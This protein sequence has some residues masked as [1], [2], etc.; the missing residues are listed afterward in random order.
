VTSRRRDFDSWDR[1]SIG[2][3]F[4]RGAIVFGQPIWIG[5]DAQPAEVEAARLA[6]QDG[7][8]A[9]HAR[10]YALVGD[11]DPGAGRSSV[12]EARARAAANAFNAEPG[13]FG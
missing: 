7:L 10:A 9:A 4:G 2:L 8:D 6:V 12:A 11:A 1:T 3:P 13:E 5:R